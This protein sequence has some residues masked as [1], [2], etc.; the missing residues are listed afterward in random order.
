MLATDLPLTVPGL[1]SAAARQWPDGL[2]LDVE[3]RPTTF[4]ELARRVEEAARGLHACGVGPG[5]RVALHLGNR[6]EWFVTQYAVAALGAWL[7]PLNTMLTVPELANVLGH[8]RPDTLVWAGEVLGHDTSARLRELLATG[9]APERIIGLDDASWP[10]G[11][12]T[13]DEVLACGA[14]VDPEVVRSL[15]SAV[16]PEDIAMIIYT[17]G[18]TGVPKGVLQTHRSLVI[19][20]RRYA[21]RLG[22]GPRDRS[23]FTSPLFWIHGCWHQSL[24]P[25]VAGSAIVLERRFSPGP[26]LRR[27]TEA[28][29][30]HLQG[31]PFQYEALLG[32]PDSARFDLSGL[33]V[34]QIGGSTFSPTLPARLRQRAPGAE[35]LAAYGLSEAGQAAYT[36]RGASLEDVATTVG[37]VHAGGEA[38]I[39]DPADR[40][41]TLGPGEAGELLL[42]CD[43]V[44]HG[45]LD[46]PEAT[47]EALAG[48]WLH[49]G[50][51]ARLDERGYL[52]ILGRNQDVYKRAG[53]TVYTAEAE[54]VLNEH[55][56]VELAAVVGI[57]DDEF[58]QVGIAFVVPS[59]AALTQGALTQAGLLEH[60]TARLARYKLPAE[61]RF[62][63]QLPMTPS[64]KVKKYEL[65]KSALRSGTVAP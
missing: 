58:G 7:V 31:V 26:V 12:D 36:P 39:V 29:C 10:A 62:V 20:M 53:A 18:T 15:A 34:I 28:G 21:G 13:W 46:A 49:T 4:G 19:S 23:I 38:R 59:E 55:R 43:C 57:P 30:T 54:A 35:L 44:M 63:P 3:G 22:L 51:L 60:L 64:G 56:G 48:G 52:T 33:R 42:R 24:V 8:A 50:D 27:L 32:H 37:T 25:L 65:A 14:T 17:S 16:T 47:A 2:W 6:L 1:V 9:A 5:S 41:V 61:I 45:Y 11:V 40:S